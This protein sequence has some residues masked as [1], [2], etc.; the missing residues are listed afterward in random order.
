MKITSSTLKAAKLIGGDEREKKCL[1]CM[2][3]LI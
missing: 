3:L 2:I 1:S